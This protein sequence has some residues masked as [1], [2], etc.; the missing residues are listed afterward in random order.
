MLRLS[1]ARKSLTNVG[2]TFKKLHNYA[3]GNSNKVEKTFF[4]IFVA[5][6]KILQRQILTVT[7]E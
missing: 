3:T 7:V 2:E 6:K 5:L 4:Q 1:S